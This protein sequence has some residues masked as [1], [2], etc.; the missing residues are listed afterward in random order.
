MIVDIRDA[1]LP[2]D[3]DPVERLWLEYLT[4]GNDGLESR[5]GFRLPVREAV[6][7]DLAT[8]SKFQRPDGRLLLAFEGDVAV[9]TACMRRIGPATAEIKRMY[10]QPSHRG[11]GVGRA[12]LDQLMA[13][14]QVAAYER[15]RLDSPDFM[16]AAHGLYRS[17]GFVEIGPYPES[18][19]PDEYR[20]HW[21]FMERTLRSLG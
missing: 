1:D 3:L 13:A 19:I 5:Y 14:A 16:T 11:A 21:V 18:E 17:D 6:K 20:P 8:I 12:L 2:R 15:V 4:W 10:V 9:G 7:H